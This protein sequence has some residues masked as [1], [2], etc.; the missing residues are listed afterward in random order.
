MFGYG[1]NFYNPK[2]EGPTTENQPCVA[3]EYIS[4]VWKL[5]DKQWKVDTNIPQLSEGSIGI[6]H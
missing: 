2:I 4:C 3:I 5:D 1:L 6:Y